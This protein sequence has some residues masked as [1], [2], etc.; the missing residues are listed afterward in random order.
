MNS[1]L[2]TG[3]E[4]AISKLGDSRDIDSYLNAGFT[5]LADELARR[6]NKTGFDDKIKKS[7]GGVEK[8]KSEFEGS[9]VEYKKNWDNKKAIFGAFAKDYKDLLKKYTEADPCH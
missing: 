5:G 2:C 9:Y 8:L 7:K 6:T 4:D 3:H 1:K